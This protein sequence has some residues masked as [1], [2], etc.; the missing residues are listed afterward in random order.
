[1]KTLMPVHEVKEHWGKEGYEKREGYGENSMMVL[2][3]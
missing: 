3:V 1:M 2:L